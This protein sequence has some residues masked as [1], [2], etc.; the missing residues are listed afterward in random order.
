MNKIRL[1]RLKKKSKFFEAFKEGEWKKVHLEHYGTKWDRRYWTPKHLQ[2]KAVLGKEVVGALTGELMAGV[3]YIPE[4][5]IKQDKRGN[6][7]GKLLIQEAERWAKKD[8]GHEI[9]LVTG[10]KW[11]AINFYQKLGYKEAARLPR[12]YSKTDFVLFRKFIT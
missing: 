3:L 5:I 7:V 10:A 8:R 4:L 12:H 2:L 1:I 6:G 9:Y 11:D